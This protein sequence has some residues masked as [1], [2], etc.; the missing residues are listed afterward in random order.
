[1]VKKKDLLLALL[2]VII[3]GA[4]FTVIKLGLNGVPSMLLVSVRYTFVAFPA[5]F[6]IKK[7]NLDWKYIICYGL[8]VGVAQFACLF[9]ALERGMPAGLASI[10]VQLQS[11]ISPLLSTLF[12]KEKL[13]PKQIIGFII[14]GSG[15]AIIGI[16]S[17]ND[18]ISSIP[19]GPLLLTICAP[20]F[21]SIS[22]IISKRCANMVADKGE[23]LDML[24][25]VVWSGLVPPIPMLLLALLINT[26]QL[27]LNSLANLNFLSIFAT[28]YV[29][30]A[31]TL[32][33]Y[34]FWNNLI[35]K[36]PLSKISPIT[37]LVPV[38]GLLIARI[39]L[40]EHLSKIQW[41][42]SLVILIGLIISNLD[43][44]QL[45]TAQKQTV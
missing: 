16:A 26:P 10:I 12:L 9:Y 27:V 11:F 4:N 33:G 44:K 32:F 2:V 22:N 23:E 34:G 13:K 19:L 15:L 25:M 30:L 39:V 6:F 8:T 38:T 28:L 1:M 3:W 45:V 36:Y 31:A 17:T 42:G 20:I 35:S 24:A 40:S 21:W 43:I 14:A 7:P 5:I 29:S 18:T 41:I 37:L